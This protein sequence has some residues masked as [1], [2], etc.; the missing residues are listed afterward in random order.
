MAT[1]IKSYFQDNCFW[2]NDQKTSSMTILC[3][4][5]D[6]GKINRSQTEVHKFNEDK[7]IAPLWNKLIEEIGVSKIDQ[8][9]EI[10]RRKKLQ[11]EN[12]KNLKKEQRE[13]SLKLEELFSLKL[14]AFEIPE[15]RECKDPVLRRKIRSS[16]NNFEM[17]SWITVVLI[18]SL[19][20]TDDTK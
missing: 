7:S 20:E 3:H 6:D 11:E 8:N 4:Q 9:T 2:T 18:K 14:Q 15:V 17:Q 12:D 19:E 5:M 13:K 10:R 16:K 1:V